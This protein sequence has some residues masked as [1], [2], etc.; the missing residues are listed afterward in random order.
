MRVDFYVGG[1]LIGSAAK[2]PW[3]V[4]WPKVIATGDYSLSARATDDQGAVA[5]ASPV[6]IRVASVT[7]DVAIIR[8]F[9]DPEIAAMEAYL[10]DLGLSYFVFDQESVTFEAVQNFKLIVWDD[11]GKAAGGLR[12]KDV[13]IFQRAYDAEIPVYL[14]GERLAASTSNLI[15]P[16]QTQWTRLVH[17]RPT[18]APTAAGNGT[19]N[20]ITDG[21]HRVINGRFGFVEN[22]AYPA[23]LDATTQTGTDQVLLGQSGDTDVLVAYEDQATGVRTVTQN[24]LALNGSNDA[25][26]I[27]ERKRLFQNAVWWLLRKPLCGLTDLLISQTAS[28]NPVR[29]GTQLAYTITVQR[30]GECEGTGVTVTATAARGKVHLG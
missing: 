19:V 4:T 14:I 24:V 8:N 9:N 27:V 6:L 22:F 2:A 13:D 12:D 25:Q 28:A 1:T 10:F 30:S 21:N 23:Q 29:T 18:T 26:S 7:A 11:L 3:T 17:L 20:I 16:V 15:A 5:T